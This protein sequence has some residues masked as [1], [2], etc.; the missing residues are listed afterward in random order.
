MILTYAED[1]IQ[2]AEST[3]QGS[4]LGAE[5]KAMVVAQLEAIGVSVNSWLSTQ[6]DAIVTALNTKG[7]WL[8]SEAQTNATTLITS[9]TTTTEG[10]TVADSK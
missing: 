3:V 4:G 2:K 7:A 10:D 8:A 9:A 5:K 1:L 6:I